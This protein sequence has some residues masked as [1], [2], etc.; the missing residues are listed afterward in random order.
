MKKLLQKIWA[1]IKSVWAKADEATKQYVPIAISVVEA[2]KTVLE[3]PVDDVLVFIAKSATPS[4]ASAALIDKINTTIKEF[5][6]KVL[7]DLK[8]VDSIANITDPNEQL[9]AILEQFKLSSDETKN[10][11]YHGLSS[12]IIEK[13]SDGVLSWSDAIAISEYYYQNIAKK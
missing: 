1:A 6:P 4:G 2:I 5:I 8:L 13:L 12:L 9:K 7:M 3:S 10:I 11:I